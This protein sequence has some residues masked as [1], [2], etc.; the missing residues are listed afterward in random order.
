MKVNTVILIVFLLTGFGSL[1][2][3]TKSFNLAGIWKNENLQFEYNFKLDSTVIFIQSGYPVG[4]IYSVDYTKSPAW[5]D[6]KITMGNSKIVTPAL[7][8][9]VD[10]NEIIIEQFPPSTKHPTDFTDNKYSKITLY[11]E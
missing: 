10:K 8:E 9:I 1:K 4:G 2:A 6:L 7:L 3:Q 5:L 11:R